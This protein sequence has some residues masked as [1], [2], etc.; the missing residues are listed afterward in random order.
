MSPVQMH[1]EIADDRHVDCTVRTC[2]MLRGCW[3]H[4]IEA[5]HP[6]P[7]D[8]PDDCPACAG[9]A[10]RQQISNTE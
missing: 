3:T 2:A 1:L 7:T 8:S 10:A 9:S 5:G 6:H 4:L